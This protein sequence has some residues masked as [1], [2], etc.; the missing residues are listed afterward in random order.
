[1]ALLKAA[2]I[3]IPNVPNYCRVLESHDFHASRREPMMILMDRITPDDNCIEGQ[4][5]V[6]A[7]VRHLRLRSASDI[8]VLLSRMSL[9]SCALLS[10]LSRRMG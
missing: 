1:V 6:R 8:R 4:W 7:E 3:K 2:V 9:R 10:S 5:Q